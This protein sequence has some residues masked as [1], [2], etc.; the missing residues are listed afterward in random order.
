MVVEEALQEANNCAKEKKFLEAV[1]IY[2][3]ILDR[4]PDNVRAKSALDKL[5]A[6]VVLDVSQNRYGELVNLFSLGQYNDAIYEA[7]KE[8][9]NFPKS[10]KLYELVASS[11]ARLGQFDDA[12]QIY[13]EILNFDPESADAHYGIGTAYG[14][15]GNYPMAISSFQAALG[16]DPSHVGAYLNLGNAQASNGDTAAAAASFRQV[17]LLD[18]NHAAACSNLGSVLHLL[19]DTEAAVESLQ[20]AIALNPNFVEAHVSLGAIRHE[21]GDFQGAVSLFRS[22]LDLKPDLVLAHKNLCRTFRVLGDYPAALKSIQT[23]KEIR[24]NDVE[25]INLLAGVLLDIDDANGAIDHYQA[26]LKI[27]SSNSEAL[28]GIGIVHLARGDVDR[29]LQYFRKSIQAFPEFSAAIKNY[30]S[31]ARVK[32]NDPII[33]QIRELGQ[34]TGLPQVDRINLAF[35]MSKVDLDLG[36][37]DDAMMHLASG[38]ALKRQ[39]LGYTIETDKS[40]FT[41]I[42]SALGVK[43]PA[44]KVEVTSARARPIFIVGMPRSGTTLVEQILASHTKVYGGGELP[45][46][47]LALDKYDWVRE[48]L[49]EEQL[50][51]IRDSYLDKLESLGG[52]PFITDKLPH[53]FR[54]VGVIARAFPEALILHVKRDAAAVCWSNYKTYFPSRGMAFSYSQR[55]VAEYYHLYEDLMNFW[56]SV[57]PNRILD[58]N[59]EKL[60]KDQEGTTRRILDVLGLNWEKSVLDFH[61]TKREV[62]TASSSQVRQ[63]LYKGSSQEWKRYKPWL[64]PMLDVLKEKNEMSSPAPDAQKLGSIATLLN[65]GQPGKALEQAKKMVDQYPSSA[66]LHNVI[67]VVL[68]QLGDPEAAV[69]SYTRALELRPDYAEVHNNLGLAL[70]ATRGKEAAIESFQQALKHNPI[71]SEAYENL[72]N[73][74]LEMNQPKLAADSYRRAVSLKPG[75]A[76]A[77]FNLGSALSFS[78][79]TA[80]AIESIERAVALDTS[81]APAY[82]LYTFLKSISK[83]DPFLEQMRNLARLSNLS[84][85][86]RIQISFALGKAEFDVGNIEAGMNFLAVGNG[87]RKSQLGYT[88]NQSRRSVARIK[89]AFVEELP[90]LKSDFAE[91]PTR[92]VFIIGM[93][94]SGTTLVEQI[95]ASHSRVFGAGELGYLRDA[96]NEVGWH[97]KPLD[98][99]ALSHI[100]S[101]YFGKLSTFPVKALTTD[102]N[103]HNFL[104]AGFIAHAFPEAKVIHVKRDPM[105]VCW[106]NYKYYFPDSGMG[107][108]FDQRDVAQYYLLYRDLMAFWHEKFPGRIY[109]LDYQSLTEDQEGETRRLL[110]EVGLEWE[111]SVLDFH[112]TER[113]VQTTSATQVRKKLYKG[114]SREWEAYKPWLGP[115]QDT[116]NA[117]YETVVPTALGETPPAKDISEI[118]ALFDKSSLKEA[119]DKTLNLVRL[120]PDAAQLHNILGVILAKSGNLVAAIDSYKRALELEPEF[121]EVYGNLGAAY[122][123]RGDIE[124]ALNCY[125]TALSKNPGFAEGHNNL[126]N[127][128][129]DMGNEREALESYRQAVLLNPNY[130]E[131]YKNLGDVYMDLGDSEKARESYRRAIKISPENAAYYRLYSRSG[132]M[133]AIGDKKELTQMRS[134][135]SRNDL[136]RDDRIQLSFALAKAEFD[137]DYL[138][139][140]MKQLNLG[141]ALQKEALGYDITQDRLGFSQIRKAFDQ[142]LPSLAGKVSPSSQRPIF[143]I[144]M[145]RS[146]TSLVEQILSSHS[147]VFGA[148][149]LELLRMAVKRTDWQNHALDETGLLRIRKEYFEGLSKFPDSRYIT[150]K[151]PLNFRWIGFAA[152]AFPEASFVHVKRNPMAVCWSNYKHFFPADGLGF[153]FD[154]RDVASYYRLYEDLMV[155][156]RDK[157]PGLIHDV[158]YEQLTNDQRGETARLLDA[159]G[160]EWEDGVLEFHKA[161]RAVKTSSSLQVRK[162]MYRGSSNEWKKFERWL[163]P[164][165]ST[166]HSSAVDERRSI[167]S[168]DPPSSE[169]SALVALHKDG[170]KQ[171]FIR[172]ATA[173]LDQ[174]QNSAQIYNLLGAGFRAIGKNKQAVSYYK[175]SIRLD[176]EHGRTHNN[177]ANVLRDM[178]EVDKAISS[179]KMAIELLPDLPATHFNLG[180]LLRDCGRE[181]A[182]ACFIR[183]IELNPSDADYHAALSMVYSDRGEMASAEQSIRKAISIKPGFAGYYRQYSTIKDISED[184]ELLEPM[185]A[186]AARGNLTREENIEISFALSKAELDL[187]NV[188]EGMRQLNLGN[189]LQKERLEYNIEKDVKRFARIKEAFLGGRQG[190]PL[191]GSSALKR[192]IFVVGMPRSGTSLTEQILASHSE[193]FGAGELSFLNRAFQGSDWMK[194]KVENIELEKI[195]SEYLEEISCL[196]DKGIIVDKHPLN[197]RWVGFIAQ[198]FP[199]ASIVHTRRDPM[200]I[201]WSNYKQFYPA[202]VMSFTFDQ[203]DIAEYYKLYRDLM[204]FW[205]ERFPGRIYDLD[206]ERLTENQEEESRKLLD[207]V[208]LNWEDGVLDFHKTERAV[209]TASKKQV[210]KK[211]Y[212]GSSR[213]WEKYRPWLRPM[214][215]V[216]EP[217]ETETVSSAAQ[218]P[219]QEQMQELVKLLQLGQL[220]EALRQGQGLVSDFPKAVGP[221]SVLGMVHLKR[222]ELDEAIEAYRA[223]IEL[224]PNNAEG[225]SNIG[226]VFRM[227]GELKEAVAWYEKALEVDP[228][229]AQAHNNLGNAL[230]D[231]KESTRAANCYRRAIDLKP[232]YAE[233]YNNLGSVLRDM[234][235]YT[236]ASQKYEK[237]I[238]LKPDYS[239]AYQNL[240]IIQIE[241]GQ[242]ALAAES[243]RR[244]IHLDPRKAENYRLYTITS[245]ATPDDALLGQMRSFAE[246]SDLTRE[247][248]IHISFALGKV[249]ADL[250]NY[251][252]SVRFL[253]TGNALQKEASGYSHDQDRTLFSNIKATFAEMDL[254]TPLLTDQST[255]RPVFVVGMPRSGTS[256]VEQIL[257]SHSQVHGAGELNL[258]TEAV[259]RTGWPE[260]SLGQSAFARIRNLYLEA[261]D[262]LPS[263]PIVV[264]K[265]PLNFRWIGFLARAFPEAAIVHTKRKPEAVCWSNFSNFFP[266]D[267]LA[268]ASSQS[269]VARY[270]NL[271]EDLMSFWEEKCPGRIL[272]LDYDRLTEDQEGETR[273]LLA[274]LGLDWED[275]VLKF[276]KTERSVRTTSSL[277]V[278]K[279]LYRGSSKAWEKFR[280]WL[281]TMLDELK[282]STMPMEGTQ[283][284]ADEIESLS[285]LFGQ[286][287]LSN[288][289]SRARALLQDHPHAAILHNILGS[290]QAAQGQFIDAVASFDAALRLDPGQAQLHFNRGNA[291][292]SCGEPAAAIASYRRAVEIDPDYVNAFFNLG[293][294]LRKAGDVT[295]ARTA[296]EKVLQLKPDFAEAY[297]S[298][299]N[300]FRDANSLDMALA[301]YRM[302]AQYL[303][304][305]AV[306]HVNMGATLA[307]IG[308]FDEAAKSYE[309]AI[310]LDPKNEDAHVGLGNVLAALGEKERAIEYYTKALR[311]NPNLSGCYRNYTAA[312]TVEADDPFLAPL[313]E[314]AARP[315]LSPIDQE[316]VAFAL[317]K[318]ELDLGSVDQGM[319]RLAEGNALRRRALGYTFEKDRR[320]FAQIVDWFAKSAPGLEASEPLARSRPIFIVGMPRSGTSL[321]EQILASH[322]QVHGAGEAN[323]LG[324]AFEKAG[325]LLRPMTAEGYTE[326][327][328]S[329]LSALRGVSDN[330]FVTDKNPLN[331]RLL[332]LILR[333][334]PEAIVIHTNRDPAAVCWS[335]YRNRYVSPAMGYAYD[336]RDVAEYYLLYEKLMAFW[337]EQFPGR[338]FDLD[339]EKLTEDQEGETKRLLEVAGLDWEEGVL[340]FH[341]TERAIRTASKYQVRQGMYRDSS[342]A[343]EAYKSWLQPMLEVLQKRKD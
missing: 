138:E 189:A 280:P 112:K 265:H 262:R 110:E 98:L 221:L 241:A 308:E 340:E 107:Y 336:Q 124:S 171:E 278:R 44:L 236:E 157:F 52:K 25:A 55:D 59:Y 293:R 314:L 188:D 97:S 136:P 253:N 12:I 142:P 337:H 148:G 68:M 3:S 100:R 76:V 224:T 103:P 338:I 184:D 123:S 183:A 45:F 2:K 210:R 69:S 238:E 320:E 111:D 261:I 304:D 217:E 165:V 220:E 313:R 120:Y 223:A 37:I 179:Y 85:D 71:Y 121:V 77:H 214:L 232:D 139:A 234:G 290:A 323:F 173:L 264:D 254:S 166:L 89:G 122:R 245:T 192:P 160:L 1:E 227:R 303:P 6:H 272:T 225:Y 65:N 88:A 15:L 274:A 198:A 276:H 282:G 149:E 306:I 147:S 56:H 16:V 40:L 91:A 64:G 140:G 128:I 152:C 78:G 226:A 36:N 155:F 170:K 176:P 294:A 252:E 38:S 218:V 167:A 75:S 8:I 196:T 53:N 230:R 335:N 250:G 187:K 329:Y 185:R 180:S 302:A 312:L 178:G 90:K 251:E 10:T 190:T 7:K 197:F 216:L 342:K 194:G 54:W 105:A 135:A 104:W 315:N 82:R 200:A 146:G 284:P 106:S 281:G 81:M 156:W 23:A 159:L 74:Y 330:L 318:A 20:K 317:A 279:G 204:D 92:P 255:K 126:G 283:P 266:A 327:R 49:T 31:A 332:G 169:L 301:N 21:Q 247:E 72:G 63:K 199:E 42:K 26:V 28:N 268:Y 60:I 193:V 202:Q 131:A 339:Y 248:K 273:G 275:S 18:P 67:G 325:G 162:K 11:H 235:E 343:W 168:Q 333:A 319:K 70:V 331:F 229:L 287:A 161:K 41:N 87:L 143:I 209:L 267:E 257:A 219:S 4:F 246:R 43:K 203:R 259:S 151:N 133:D 288:V 341:K 46:L 213:A 205:H 5:E 164:M 296:F 244:A 309:H 172:R 57:F 321:V 249:E 299:G 328:S 141:S 222:G 117:P 93:P 206:Y 144:G 237:A 292:S 108:S 137:L 298:L 311:L 34:K 186:L 295:G 86:D 119:H 24:P 109:D 231:Q 130:A 13:N 118:T 310:A 297:N 154:Q 129:C 73:V 9:V 99:G 39:E 277:Q 125:R 240:G 201:C 256:L 191:T 215:E 243:F 207:A 322:S 116:L 286:G 158:D 208:N 181:G 84:N 270:Y 324:V 132:A 145:P 95:L 96:I 29:A 150:D 291:L 285:K 47:N 50:Q 114:S 233:A 94:R 334:L 263:S 242:G 80:G 163:E 326:V 195:R 239:E 316:N 115:M 211:M 228:G 212:Q 127:V 182:E 102:K 17:L 271:Y 51:E 62:R 33:G 27:D 48:P 83:G 22:A 58:V 14:F 260:K 269:D 300:I 61:Q 30:V 79:D 307:D 32:P 289:V 101:S 153:S 19:G 35:A 258:I 175:E 66:L 174:Y 305:K 134:L 113:S 177:L